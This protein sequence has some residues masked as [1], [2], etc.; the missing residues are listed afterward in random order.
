MYVYNSTRVFT[1][2]VTQ[3]LKCTKSQSHYLINENKDITV[4]EH[5]KYCS[6]YTKT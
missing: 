2:H 1:S 3:L 5:C 6:K 4:Q